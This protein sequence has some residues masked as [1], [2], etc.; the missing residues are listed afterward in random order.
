LTARPWSQN[1]VLINH[2]DEAIARPDLQSIWDCQPGAGIFLAELAEL[3]PERTGSDLLAI[4]VLP[5]HRLRLAQLHAGGGD[6][7]Q[8]S[9]SELCPQVGVHLIVEAGI[10]AFVGSRHRAQIYRAG[11]RVDDA[12]PYT[13]SATWP[14][15]MPGAWLLMPPTMTAGITVL[16]FTS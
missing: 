11:I 7:D 14:T 3:L 8:H 2:D 12:V 9:I 5:V 1:H 4:V 6:A 16:A 13:L 15:I 10:A